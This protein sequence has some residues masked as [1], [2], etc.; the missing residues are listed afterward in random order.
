MYKKYSSVLLVLAKI[1]IVFALSVISTAGVVS[2]ETL[3]EGI[4]VQE[5]FDTTLADAIA[6]SNLTVAVGEIAASEGSSIT[7]EQDPIVSTNKA[8]KMHF[9]NAAVG[10]GAAARSLNF[11]VPIQGIP[12]SGKLILTYKY[13]EWDPQVIESGANFG[14]A[15]VKWS[16][17]GSIFNSAGSNVAFDYLNG[18][19]PFVYGGMRLAGYAT[20][21]TG[22]A[23]VPPAS[24]YVVGSKTLAP[25]TWRT[26]EITLELD[27][28]LITYKIDGEVLLGGASG[29]TAY[30]GSSFDNGSGYLQFYGYDPAIWNTCTHGGDFWLDDI[31]VKAVVPKVL[32]KGFLVQESFNTTLASAIEES[33]L[34]VAVGEIAASEGSS[35][36][37]EQDPIVSTNKALKMHFANAAV[38][39]GAAARSLSFSV[40]VEGIPE[41]GKLIL[42]Y[43]YLEWDPQVIESGANFGFARVKW[44]NR[45]SIF[46]SAGNNVAFDYLD[47]GTPF[48]YNG[49][50]LAGYATAG[51]GTATVPP[52]SGYVVGAKTLAPRTW[53]T[54]EVTLDL[55]TNLITYKIDGEVLLGGASGKTAYMG[56]SFANG[57]GYLMFYGYDPAIWKTCT[58]GGDFWL[59][60]IEVKAVEPLSITTDMPTANVDAVSPFTIKFNNEVTNQTDLKNA[61]TITKTSDNSTIDSGRISVI[62]DAD[63]LG[64]SIVVTGDL[65][66]G[67]TE[68]TLTIANTFTDVNGMYSK[69]V[70]EHAFTTKFAAG[71]YI[72]PFV[73]VYSN[74]TTPSASTEVS[75][76][77]VI[78]NP[79][80]VPAGA[81]VALAVYDTDNE[82]LGVI[83][84]TFGSIA[85]SG[86]DNQ[87]LTITGIDG[88]IKYVKAFAWNSVLNLKPYH[89]ARIVELP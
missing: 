69:T 47:G 14:F 8:L 29:K 83:I 67:E 86:S 25:R 48:G 13:L 73:P 21:G 58:H 26:A 55:D 22:T 17:R 66:Y 56:S 51:T 81:W 23:T 40:P 52:A 82:M 32:P 87:V 6:D 34:G 74:P 60:D 16:N 75:A 5:S 12:E 24:G 63:K 80:T 71:M 41:S 3:P 46:N 38:G 59:D 50:R 89:M 53:R 43:K 68:Y 36:T 65:E 7:L 76:T 72:E 30:M 2:A 31:E 84:T 11:S 62:L 42:T 28:Q 45:G 54:A 77:I 88:T 79:T 19:T 39:S 61:I 33:N 70:F 4:L 20:A 85:A 57:S 44:S 35:I 1:S 27:T 10:S 9:A 49:M 64:A 78:Q 18:A 37:L 15:R